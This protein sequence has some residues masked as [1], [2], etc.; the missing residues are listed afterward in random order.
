MGVFSWCECT[1]NEEIMVGE[2]KTVYLL[3][4]KEFGGGHIEEPCYRG[5][6][7][8]GNY[9][10]YDLIA[11][12]NKSDT[13]TYADFNKLPKKEAYI[14]LWDFQRE[15]L[16]KEGLSDDELKIKD[17]EEQ[18]KNYQLALKRYRNEE[19][20]FNSFMQDRPMPESFEKR[21]IGITLVHSDKKIQYPVKISF[22]ENAVYEDCHYSPIAKNQGCY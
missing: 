3:I 14:G 11:D 15:A 7:M 8:F 13:L 21:E 19:A 20:Q 4:P 16:R 2:P 22:D 18:E 10:V 9:D 12:W 6:G 5:Y 17:Q 1:T